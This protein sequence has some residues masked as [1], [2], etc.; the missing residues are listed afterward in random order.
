MEW[1]SVSVTARL[2]ILPGGA[3]QKDNNYLA[4]VIVCYNIHWGVVLNKHAC[5][6]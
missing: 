1:S 2:V 5:L 6:R 3:I 4:I